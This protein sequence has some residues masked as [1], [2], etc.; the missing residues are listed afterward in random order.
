MSGG[1]RRRVEECEGPERTLSPKF[2]ASIAF[3]LWFLTNAGQVPQR[4]LGPVPFSL[5]RLNA[6]LGV[7]LEENDVDT[8]PPAPQ[9]TIPGEYT[10]MEI[11]R[12]HIHGAVG[13]A[14]TH[15]YQ[16]T[17]TSFW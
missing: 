6:I 11:T 17:D 7:L 1:R 4:L 8:R 3:L 5:D 16:P 13:Y 10:D 15:H 12:V 2:V 14:F 9:F